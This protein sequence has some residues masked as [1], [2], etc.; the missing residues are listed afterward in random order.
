MQAFSTQVAGEFHPEVLRTLLNRS[1]NDYVGGSYSMDQQRFLRFLASEAVDLSV[2]VVLLEDG[3]PIGL[4]LVSRRGWSSRLVLMGVVEEARGRRSG[5]Y[6]LSVLLEEAKNRGDRF[7]HLEVIQAN[8]PAVVLYEK[9]GFEKVRYL[10]A[11]QRGSL[12]EGATEDK[13]SLAE[14]VQAVDCYEVAQGIACEGLARLAWQVSDGGVARLTD[15]MQA[16]RLDGAQAVV[17]PTEADFILRALIVKQ[18]LRKQGQ[19]TALLKAINE[20]HP[21][22]GW[23]VP[24]ICPEE[25]DPFFQAMGFQQQEM[26]QY[27][28]VHIL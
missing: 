7:Y 13:H 28:M 8:T 26:R 10:Y 24:A 27:Q 21:E 5:T 12:I 1:F 22:K 16:Y 18:A 3:E 17:L 9:G 23:Y 25:L 15:P 11:Y 6:L 20:Q 14:R 19:A 2:S 4:G